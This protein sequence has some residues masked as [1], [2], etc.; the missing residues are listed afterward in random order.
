VQKCP[1]SSF[2]GANY[3]LKSTVRFFW[4]VGRLIQEF[5]HTFECFLKWFNTDAGVAAEPP[6]EFRANPSF[7][8]G[9]VGY[10]AEVQLL[11]GYL[12]NISDKSGRKKFLMVTSPFLIKRLQLTFS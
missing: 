6:V 4:L 7:D 5:A 1:N 3:E 10:W 11:G 8:K 2:D 12:K 9:E